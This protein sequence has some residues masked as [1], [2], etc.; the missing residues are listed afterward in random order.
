M[1]V[2]NEFS[3]E[4]FL[5]DLFRTE[6]YGIAF[7]YIDCMEINKDTENILQIINERNLKQCII[8]DIGC[9]VRF[10]DQIDC[11]QYFDIVSLW[12]V[13]E[14][15][16]KKSDITVDITGCLGKISI[17]NQSM[18]D[19]CNCAFNW[20]IEDIIENEWNDIVE[21]YQNR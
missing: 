17:A 19:K 5:R 7:H 16:R 2:T 18:V 6:I 13:V 14:Y 1:E 3:E 21:C 11:I 8:D 10:E 12:N 20:I 4:T 9:D 15:I